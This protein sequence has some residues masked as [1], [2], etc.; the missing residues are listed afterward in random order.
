M[1]V[2]YRAE[3]T[4]LKRIV[5]LKF[6]PSEFTRDPTA[7]ARFIHE[8]QAASALDHSNICTI[9]EIDETN[10][11][12]LFISM[13]YYEGET[14]KDEIARGEMSF[15]EIVRIATHI[16]QGLAK[17]H[18]KGIVHRD[19]K[20]ANIII[21]RDG[22]AK[23]LDFGLAKLAGQ[24][25][26]TT[27]PSTMGTIT[28]MSPEQARGAEV[29]QR[30]DIWSLGVVLYEMVA[31][32]PPFTSGYDQALI[33]SILNE[34]PPPLATSR[35]QTP[36]R[37]QLVIEKALRKDP[38]E[39][40]QRMGELLRDLQSA[41]AQ[42][43]VSKLAR[44]LRLSSTR[45][46]V[47]AVVF[48]CA[49]LFLG[50]YAL[51]K[52]WPSFAGRG[53]AISS[54]AVLPFQNFS[55]GADEEYFS[56]GITEALISQLAQIKALRVISRTSA[57]RYR[58]SEKSLPE[59]AAALNVESIVEGS[60]QRVGDSVHVTAQLIRAKP[61]RHIWAKEF[62][63]NCRDILALQS[64]VAQ[65]ITREI[66][67]K[68]TPQEKR[69][70]SAS[71]PVDPAA[72]ENYLKGRFFIN[73]LTVQDT[74][75]G[76]SYFESAVAIDSSYAP[77]YVGL[78]EG[79][80][81]LGAA[82]MTP[83]EAWPK[84]MTQARKALSLDETLA[85]AYSLLADAEVVYEWNWK[86]A[87]TYY[88]RA[89]DL[90]P[91]LAIAHAYYSSYLCMM[92]RFDDAIREAK[93]ARELDPLSGVTN[94]ILASA[95]YYDGQHEQAMRQAADFLSIDSTFTST[96]VVL[97][98]VCLSQRNPAQAIAYYH[99]ALAFGDRSVVPGLAR[100][101]AEAGLEEDAR[102]LLVG[103]VENPQDRYTSPI[104]LAR[105]YFALG[106][107]DTAFAYLDRAY[108]D[109]NPGLLAVGLD[110]ADASLAADPRF[111]AIMKKMGLEQR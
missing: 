3:D 93:R 111:K 49:V 36:P 25:R 10:D 20:P 63:R 103:V 89:I 76:L 78:A 108:E 17:A 55:P 82:S 83:A 98:S 81:F 69:L 7:K 18:E 64:D 73:K 54:L 14:L 72:Y 22:T 2:V 34:E 67:V 40:Y 58:K 97:A 35:P 80:D 28:Y 39:R 100:A 74:R 47:A 33:Y 105:V 30:S 56:D 94:I 42:S 101:Y 71:R 87:E 19:V 77:A 45:R 43:P 41:Q 96:Y 106:S 5:A 53:R 62:T 60:V 86:E 90:N 27:T 52:Q 32:R 110:P 51:F 57:M 15:E 8:A 26:L 102:R 107:Q 88:K 29:D 84:V 104:D 48:A 1:G 4:K 99:K 92:R 6:L 68:V 11:G 61:E 50:G 66:R 23:I 13:A 9:Y 75:R 70:L 65:T 21:T 38:A 31:G 24:T 59:I 46:R 16:G 79:Y 12:H 85:E 91:N 95:Y 37:L 109:R 44:H